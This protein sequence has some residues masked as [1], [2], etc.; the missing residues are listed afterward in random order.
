MLQFDVRNANQTQTQNQVKGG[1]TVGGKGG[2]NS[3]TGG[4]GGSLSVPVSLPPM[5]MR[6][7]LLDLDDVYARDLEAEYELF[8][9]EAF[10]DPEAEAEAEF[11]EDELEY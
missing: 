9:R 7:D 4:A 10:A 5:P 8:A 11:F 3:G 6:R 2:V 1:N